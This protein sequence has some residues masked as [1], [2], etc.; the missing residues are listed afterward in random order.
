L[1]HSDNPNLVSI[2]EGE[3]FEATRDIKVDEE[4]F[5]DYGTIVEGDE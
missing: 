4:L 1:N 3:Y 2:N 5:L